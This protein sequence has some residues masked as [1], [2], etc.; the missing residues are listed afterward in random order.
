MARGFSNL[1]L[2]G[3]TPVRVQPKVGV[4]GPA[5]V[6]STRHKKW[7][8]IGAVVGF[9]VAFAAVLGWATYIYFSFMKG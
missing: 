6:P 5:G 3:P 8:R 9:V 1:D 4:W 2:N 7:V